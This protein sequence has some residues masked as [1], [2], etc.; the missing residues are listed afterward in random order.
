MKKLGKTILGATI[1][2]A[3]VAA[4]PFTGTKLQES[5]YRRPN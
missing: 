3:A 1:G 5:R 2:V 4:A